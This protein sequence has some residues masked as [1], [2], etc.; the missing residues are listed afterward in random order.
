MKQHRTPQY[1]DDPNYITNINSINKEIGEY[2]KEKQPCK[3]YILYN[4]L[5]KAGHK[6][7]DI[8]YLTYQELKELVPFCVYTRYAKTKF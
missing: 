8:E 3:E 1:T 5:I 4:K 2:P 7:K 6:R